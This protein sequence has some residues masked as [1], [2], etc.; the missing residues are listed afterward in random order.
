MSRKFLIGRS[1][2]IFRR[3]FPQAFCAELSFDAQAVDQAASGGLFIRQGAAY[4]QRAARTLQYGPAVQA[5]FSHFCCGPIGYI[6]S[7]G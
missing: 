7:T 6:S 4:S 5:V 2:Q 1:L 3:N